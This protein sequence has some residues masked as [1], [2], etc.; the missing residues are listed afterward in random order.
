[1]ASACEC[2]HTLRGLCTEHPFCGKREK[3]EGRVSPDRW[4]DARVATGELTDHRPE[5]G[6]LLWAQ[7]T[8]I[9]SLKLFSVNLSAGGC[10]QVLLN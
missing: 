8:G 6:G 3:R 9:E 10:N 7:R 2:R 4:G 5:T 1:M